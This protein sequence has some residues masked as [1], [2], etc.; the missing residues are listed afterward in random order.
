MTNTDVQQ[1]GKRARKNRIPAPRIVE[2]SED[3]SND[4]EDSAGPDN[5]P[6]FNQVTRSG[7]TLRKI[8]D[9]IDKIENDA[10]NVDSLRDDMECVIG[11][12]RKKNIVLLPC[13]HQHTCEQCWCIIKTHHFQKIP[14]E[15]LNETFN[16]NALK[17]KCPICK[18]YVDEELKVFN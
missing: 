17:P 14:I 2:E 9:V 6:I 3:D 8:K 5:I 15:L 12:G 18:R 1:P 7:S 13:L 10:L 4:S 11:C 16:D